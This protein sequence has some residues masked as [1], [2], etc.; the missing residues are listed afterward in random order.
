MRRLPAALLREM[1]IV[2][3]PGETRVKTNNANYVSVML[4][5]LRNFLFLHI[6]SSTAAALLR[7]MNIVDTPG[8]MRL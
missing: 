4:V 5:Q 3:T 2:D 1:N 6:I 7:E 8:G